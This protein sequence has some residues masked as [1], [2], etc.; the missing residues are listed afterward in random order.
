MTRIPGTR[1]VG[2]V[3][4][5][6]LALVPM[7]GAIPASAAQR[8]GLQG[9]RSYESPQ[10]GYTVTWDE[11][12]SVRGRDVISNPGGFDTLVLRGPGTLMVQGQGD[13][14]SA[15]D[16][17]QARVGI[18]GS[19]RDVISSNLDGEVPQVVMQL[20]RDRV[21]I[22][23]YTLPENDAVVVVVLSARERDFE[24]AL[25]SVHEQVL[26]N[27]GQLLTGEP[28]TPAGDE[29]TAPEGGDAGEP[30]TTEAPETDPEPTGEGD[31]A[32]APD[33][34]D[35]GA[36][37]G[38]VYGYSLEYDASL[39][40][41]TDEIQSRDSDGLQMVTDTGSL[42]IWGMNQYG[43]DPVACLDGESDYYATQDDAVEDW[44]PALDADGEPIRY[45]TDDYA[46]GVFTLTHTDTDGNVAE[47]VDY[48][49]CRTVPGADAVVIIMG[50]SS[51][52]L[53]NDHLDHVL[54]VAETITFAGEDVSETQTESTTTTTADIP[55]TA[56]EGSLYTSPSF[57][58]TV[59][60]PVQW[61]VVDESLDVNDEQL[62]LTNGTSQ[63]TLWA[64]DSY[65]GDLEGCVDFAAE[66][67]P[68]A[69]ELAENADGDPFRGADRNG[70]YG[71][72]LYDDGEQAYFISCRAIVEDESVL[73]LMQDV[74]ASEQAA[75]RK[76]RID[77]QQS[78][79]FP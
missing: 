29:A 35:D 11:D 78:I 58:F 20:P 25:A 42:M 3:I 49:E 37:T 15:V 48:I 62:M 40:N 77:L 75:E 21:L 52:E 8:N 55:E 7:L 61:S 79:D 38:T 34:S 9:D 73:I 1:G 59:D 24:D 64:T 4:A 47:L 17:V 32:P 72:F 50:S 69:L 44:A 53:Y 43:S 65:T 10:F 71:N 36:Y 76:F 23:G 5:L 41:V 6:L 28:I 68:H 18:E 54:D 60:I 39:W 56:L 14:A 26:F 16:A 66:Q 63:V 30:D 46:Y 67:A 70:A 31:A 57:G 74:P 22:E 2:L 45:E 19:E 33:A 27:D 13:R 51:P 12:W